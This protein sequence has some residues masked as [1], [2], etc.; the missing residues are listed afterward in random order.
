[1]DA[2][3]RR[4]YET[5]AGRWIATRGPVAVADGRLDRFAS[6]LRPGSRVADLGSGPGWYADAFRA[7]GHRALA[8][9]LSRAMLRGARDR[10]A[11]LPCACADLARLPLARGAFD[12]AW[13]IN[14]YCHIPVSE[15]PA[16]LAEL[17]A[18]LATGAPIEL[19]L[20]DLGF[21]EDRTAAEEARGE[22]ERRM[23][24]HFP[25]RLFTYFTAGRLRT[26]MTGAGFEGVEIEPG[27]SWWHVVRARRALTLPDF[28][29]PGLRLLVCG[30][31][32]SVYAAE[33]G[34]PFARPGNR[35]W[36]AARAAG[37]VD[38]DRDPLAALD[39]GLGFTDLCK[40]ATRR[41]S[42][43]EPAEYREGLERVRALVAHYAPR[44]VCL[45]GLEGWRRAADRS[46]Q[47]GWIESGLGGRP[48]YLMP[49]TS[50]LN[51]HTRPE[52][53]ARHLREAARPPPH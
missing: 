13:A 45:V 27:S 47:P 26:L 15:L 49:S 39:A 7:R 51:A 35:F 30:L 29:R 21:V 53:F 38:R 18:A 43:L 17:H 25:G 33:R 41:A 9:D 32:P 34:I 46:A 6:R 28:V 1:M 10:A 48:A 3:T 5:E 50:G 11:D 20:G 24:R 4:I 40:R 16:A 8:L 36:P 52:G 23:T 12:A 42:E 19:T 22:A 14:T 37:L 44:A 2:R 31:N